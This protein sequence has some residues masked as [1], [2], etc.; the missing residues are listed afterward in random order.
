MSDTQ[1]SSD[2]KWPGGTEPGTAAAAPVTR[3][4][5]AQAAARAAAS[6]SRRD[7]LEYLRLRRKGA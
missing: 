6:A 2:G 3:E 4:L 7:L 1:T 5:L